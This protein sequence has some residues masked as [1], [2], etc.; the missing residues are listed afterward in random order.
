MSTFLNTLLE[1]AQRTWADPNAR[2]ALLGHVPVVFG[3]LGILPLLLLLLTGFKSAA[4]RVTVILWFLIASG[5]AY[6]AREAGED[7]EHALEQR[8][9][10]LSPVEH[11]A[12]ERHEDLAKN[13][14]IW[15]LIPAGLGLFMLARG[16]RTQV[17]AGTLTIV[18]ATGVACVTALVGHT[19]GRLVYVYGLGVPERGAPADGLDAKP[20]V[21]TTSAAPEATAPAAP[22]QPETTPASTPPAS[23]PPSSDPPP[24]DPPPSSPPSD[25]PAD[26]PAQPP[27]SE[28]PPPRG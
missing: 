24:S 25:P 2:H 16:R 7:A 20:A 23:S 13:A 9:P 18:A 1:E 3:V 6:L 22:A 26:P 15:P 12:F 27:P 17:I 11:A 14:W 21:P 5:G 10:A 28:A 19:G 4:L 8:Q